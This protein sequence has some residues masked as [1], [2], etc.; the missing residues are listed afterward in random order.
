VGDKVRANAGPAENTSADEEMLTTQL[1]Q[2]VMGWR[3]APGRFLKPQRGWLP[4]SR[5]KP[6]VRLD[7]AFL[8]LDTA[9]AVYNLSGSAGVF[10]ARVRAG[11]GVGKASGRL[12]A[13]TITLAL[14]HALGIGAAH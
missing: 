5:F 2:I 6:F 4:T 12:K 14:S 7:H 13:R 10:T 9:R 8:L 3:I 11:R 1:A